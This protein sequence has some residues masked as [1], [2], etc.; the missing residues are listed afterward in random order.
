MYRPAPGVRGWKAV[1]P[2]LV[3]E[4]LTLKDVA[5]VQPDV[6]FDV[7]RREHLPFNDAVDNI[8][9]KA[10]DLGQRRIGH[11]LALLCP[12]AVSKMVWRVLRE[13]THHV[14]SRGATLASYA[15]WKYSSAQCGAA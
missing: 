10:R 13:D 3:R 14:P 6:R 11:R 12:G 5:A 8:R 9:G 15:L 4:A 1:A 7:G 2:H